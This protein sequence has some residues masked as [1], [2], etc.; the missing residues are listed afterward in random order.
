MMHAFEQ[1]RYFEYEERYDFR[2]V[3]LLYEGRNVSMVIF[4]PDRYDGLHDMEKNMTATKIQNIRRMM[5]FTKTH[6]TVP[7]FKFQTDYS[8]SR[9][10]RELGF[11]RLFMSG[12]NLADM[13]PE[14]T[15]LI[16]DDVK[17]KATIEVNEEGS[18]AAAITR[19]IMMKSMPE[20]I[21]DPEFAVDHPFL[22]AIFDIRNSIILFVGRV[23]HFLEGVTA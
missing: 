17:H 11:K 14:G 1:V 4:L 16:L 7:K 18:A 5:Y 15:D 3:E 19:A 20:T 12:A 22:F 21:P 8:L 2:A 9:P 10:L 13:I 23:T 6:L